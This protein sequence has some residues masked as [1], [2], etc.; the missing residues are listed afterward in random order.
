M[1][2]KRGQVRAE[3]HLQ[4]DLHWR[5]YKDL[6]YCEVGDVDAKKESE[7]RMDVR[8]ER[9]PGDELRIL[10]MRRRKKQRV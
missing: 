1:D 9:G 3:M 7:T 4:K 8:A 5:L 10:E 6:I 2:L